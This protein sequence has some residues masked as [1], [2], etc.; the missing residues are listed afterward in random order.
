MLRDD[1]IEAVYIGTP[2]YLHSEQ[3]RKAADAGKHILCEKPL[4]MTIK[5]TERV[6]EYCEK[7]DVTLQAGFMM[8]YHGYHIMAK[9]MIRD[10]HE[11]KKIL[12]LFETIFEKPIIHPRYI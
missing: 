1:N 3:V 8:R 2:L 5:E 4:A 7:K 9:E 10:Y 12:F 6:I 11:P